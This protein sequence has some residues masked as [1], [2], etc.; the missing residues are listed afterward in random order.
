MKIVF[1][2]D[3][4]KESLSALEAADA[5]ERGFRSVF[6][7]AVYKK[8]PMADGGEGTVQS[9]VDATSGKIEERFVTGPLGKPVKA[10]FGLMGD[11]EQLS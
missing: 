9:L 8:M 4:Y 5:M 11:G 2:P 7:D 10:F 6:P 3:S 1:A